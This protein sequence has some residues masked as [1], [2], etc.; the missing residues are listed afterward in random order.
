MLCV[1]WS[2]GAIILTRHMVDISKNNVNSE[3]C[4]DAKLSCG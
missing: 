2:G 3:N 1:L 4:S